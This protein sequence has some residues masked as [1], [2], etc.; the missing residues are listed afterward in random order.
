MMRTNAGP[1]RVTRIGNGWRVI[2]RSCMCRDVNT[3]PDT[4]C[5]GERTCRVCGAVRRCDSSGKEPVRWTRMK[6]S[7]RGLFIFVRV[8]REWSKQAE[9]RKPKAEG[10]GGCS[11]RL[12]VPRRMSVWCRGTACRGLRCITSSSE[13]RPSPAPSSY[14]VASCCARSLAHNALSPAY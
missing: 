9:G 3:G 1:R 14:R 10:K 6:K 2:R 11:I 5:S 7:G 8:A 4:S 13:G 12:G